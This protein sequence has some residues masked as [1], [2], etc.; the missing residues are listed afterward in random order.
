MVELK[1]KIL[2]F[3]IYCSIIGFSQTTYSNNGGGIKLK[4]PYFV[5]NING[6]YDQYVNE[7]QISGFSIQLKSVNNKEEIDD[8]Y[9]KI[10][11]KPEYIYMKP[12]LDFESPYFKLRL[13][14][15]MDKKIAYR[16]L[17]ELRRTYPE[18]IIVSSKF[19]MKDCNER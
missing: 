8:L 16:D 19:A 14:Y 7:V 12:R 15:Y 9:N 5:E 2:L 10:T 3:S 17:M 18:A 4:E 6:I 11:D 1:C 13:G